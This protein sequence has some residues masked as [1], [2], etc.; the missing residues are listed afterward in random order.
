M[1]EPDVPTD[2]KDP[3]AGVIAAL[4]RLV[5]PSTPAEVAAATGLPEKT[6]R[7]TLGR[8]V[9]RR[10]ARRDAEELARTVERFA[11]QGVAIHAHHLNFAGAA[12]AVAAEGTGGVDCLLA[13]LGVSSMQIDRP[14][15]G[16]SFKTDGP[17]DMRMDRGRGLSA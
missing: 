7:R 10:E 17:L 3:A 6:V 15:R 11:T 9:S 16:F 8:L 2:P 1:T 12:K 5:V 13:D 14:D 4:R